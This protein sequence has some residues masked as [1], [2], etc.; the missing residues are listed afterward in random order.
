MSRLP[1][2]ILEYNVVAEFERVA[3]GNNLNIQAP[4]LEGK[5]G[6]TINLVVDKAPPKSPHADMDSRE[7]TLYESHLAF[8]WAYIYSSFVIYEECVQLPL[9]QET[10][11]GSIQFTTSLTRRAKS[12]QDWAFLF[13]TQYSSWDDD[14][15]PSPRRYVSDKEQ[16]YGEKANAIFQ[17]AVCFLLYHEYAHLTLGHVAASDDNSWSIEQEKDA[18]NFALQKVVDSGAPEKEQ[19][20]AGVALVL[21]CASNFFLPRG[22]R[23][24]WQRAHP[25][26][27]DRLRHALSHLGLD[28][29]KSKFY[30]YYLASISIHQYLS[31]KGTHLPLPDAESAEDLFFEYLDMI[32]G[33]SN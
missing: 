9:I 16:W 29:D 24:I 17:T 4:V 33:L 20:R 8:I 13:S 5:V 23:G 25:N 30:L 2:S 7:I 15:L 28:S 11:D 21:I 3:K 14:R 10:F 12:L 32:D 31:S 26:L 18:D 1:V 27:H 6:S 22:L 19:L